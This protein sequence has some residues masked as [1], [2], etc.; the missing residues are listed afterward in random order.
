M[1]LCNAS[2]WDTVDV[3][4]DEQLVGYRQSFSSD[5]CM[6]VVNAVEKMYRLHVG[7]FVQD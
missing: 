6:L 5:L 4:A 1:V 3:C 7:H 2:G